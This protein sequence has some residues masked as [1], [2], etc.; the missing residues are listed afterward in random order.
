MLAPGNALSFQ[1]WY[2]LLSLVC[3]AKLLTLG[4]FS[5][6]NVTL[7]AVHQLQSSKSAS[8]L[9]KGIQ[10]VSHGALGHQANPMARCHFCHPELSAALRRGFPWRTAGG[11]LVVGGVT[12][13]Q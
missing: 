13:A 3:H 2:L 1:W 5:L 12:S 10:I 7:S 6:R 8:Q 9:A 11:L 4:N